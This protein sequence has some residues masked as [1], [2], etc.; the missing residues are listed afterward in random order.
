MLAVINITI[1]VAFGMLMLVYVL[2][3]VLSVM[4]WV[5]KL[6]KLNKSAQPSKTLALAKRC[7]GLYTGLEKG[8]GSFFFVWISA[9]QINWITM[10]FLAISKATDGLSD[11]F[12]VAEFLVYILGA[13]ATMI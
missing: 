12:G 5:S 8:M 10:T 11:I 2:S 1:T 7:L 3:L 13:I 4:S 9:A 6:T